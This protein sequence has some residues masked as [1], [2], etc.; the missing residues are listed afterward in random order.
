MNASAPVRA[1]V[2]GAGHR[3]QLYA[4]YALSHPEE[5]KI[6]AVVDVDEFRRGQMAQSHAIPAEMSFGTVE[7]FLRKPRS[8]D[9]VINGTMDPLHIPTSVP[10]LAAGYHMLLEKPIGVTQ[11]EVMTLAAVAREHHSKVMICHVLRYAPF[12]VEIRKR[13]AA[14]EIGEIVSIQTTEHVSYHHMAVAF[15]RGKWSRADKSSPMLMSKCCHDLDLI[16]WMKSGIAPRSVSSFGSRTYFRPERA[17][18]GSGTRC[19][20]DCQIEANCQYSARKHYIEMGL[21]DVYAFQGI[22]HMAPTSEQKIESLRTDN[23]YGR[24][25]W[26]CDNDVVDRQT[27]SVEFADGCTVTH[28]MIGGVSRPGRSIHL[29]GT[30]GEIQGFME[31]SVFFVRHP[32]PTPGHEYF[33][34]RVDTTTGDGG[35]GGGDLRLVADFVRVLRGESASISTTS[36][37]DSVRGHL[38]GFAA[39]KSR[40][41]R[42]TVNVGD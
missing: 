4:S 21:W 23:P 25:V 11:D 6:V 9:A 32:D 35:H 28:N 41:E 22:E 13:V 37:E 33:E 40:H 26:R 29:V 14:G 19:M 27:V 18:A 38:I 16:A 7:E 24:C 10:L 17:P 15:I 1:A 2:V 31:D 3:G 34:E 39:E 20:V 30:E 42:T 12:Y 5:L 36:L 8:V